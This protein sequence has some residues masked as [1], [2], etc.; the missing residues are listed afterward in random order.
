MVSRLV[1]LY[2]TSNLTRLGPFTSSLCFYLL[3]F[4]LSPSLRRDP[5]R[6]LGGHNKN[7]RGLL[8]NPKSITGG[9]LG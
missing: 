3:A 2:S 9:F 6:P 4:S 7:G 5:A 1:F 8:R